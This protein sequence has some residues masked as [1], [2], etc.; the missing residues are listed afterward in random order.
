MHIFLYMSNILLIVLVL[1]FDG[2]LLRP[3]AAYMRQ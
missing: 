1:Y 3:S 2:I